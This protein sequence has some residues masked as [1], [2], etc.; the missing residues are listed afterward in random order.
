MRGPQ[1][2]TG[3]R[4]KWEE[5]AEGVAVWEGLL[6]ADHRAGLWPAQGRAG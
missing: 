4:G 6:Q 2:Q 3:A 1:G 5:G